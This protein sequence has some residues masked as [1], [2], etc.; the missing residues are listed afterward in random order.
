MGSVGATQKRS[1]RK[2]VYKS[3]SK[4]A[5]EINYRVDEQ[6]N[7]TNEQQKNK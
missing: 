7:Q 6:K 2:V 1:I 4:G 3:K 5:H